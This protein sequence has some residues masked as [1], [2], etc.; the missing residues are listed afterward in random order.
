[1]GAGLAERGNG[2]SPFDSKL[3]GD[4]PQNFMQAIL[5]GVQ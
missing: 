1:M 5:L 2:N 4:Q 3:S